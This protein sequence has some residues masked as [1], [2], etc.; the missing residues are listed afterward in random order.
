[1]AQSD[2]RDRLSRPPL[3]AKRPRSSPGESTEQAGAWRERS[4]ASGVKRAV[5][6]GRPGVASA[7]RRRVA[8]PFLTV[9]GAGMLSGVPAFFDADEAI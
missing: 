5:P 6:R 8:G 7:L 4:A 2:Q 9:L 1:M 3:P